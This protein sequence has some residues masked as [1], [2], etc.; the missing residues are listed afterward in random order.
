MATG[1]TKRAP[2][3]AKKKAAKKRGS[4]KKTA[5]KANSGARAGSKAK[6]DDAKPT[7]P[8]VKSETRLLETLT[9]YANNSRTHSDEQI[10]A[11]CRSIEEFGWTMPILVDENDEIIAGH[12]RA[13]AAAKLEIKTVPVMVARGWTDEQRRAYVIADNKLTEM[14]G[15][16]EQILKFELAELDQL[17]FDFT[18]TGF[19]LDFLEEKK[20]RKGKTSLQSADAEALPEL[21][22]V[23]VAQP[24]DIFILGDHRIMCGDSTKKAHVDKLMKGCGKINT[25][26]A[27]PPYGMGKESEGVA[28]DNLYGEKLDAFQMQWW[29]RAL[30]HCEK[31]GSAYIWG[32]APDLWRLWYQGGLSESGELHLRN[33]IVWD[34]SSAIGMKAP[35]EHSYPNA[36]ERCLFMMMGQQFLGNQNKDAYWE[37]YEPLRDWMCKERDKVGWKAKQVNEL[38][39]TNMAGHWFGKSQFAVIPEDHY[40]KLQEAAAGKAFTIPYGKLFVEIFPGLV[41]GGKARRTDLQE[42]LRSLRS[43]FDNTHDVMTDVW[44]FGRVRGEDRF[45]HATPKPVQLIGRGL[46]TSTPE[47]GLVYDPFAGTGTTLIAADV[48]G[49]RCN[50]IE[51]MPHYV[52]VVIRRWQQH[53]DQDAKREDGRKFNDLE[54][55]AKANAENK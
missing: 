45:G 36:T 46:R 52:D 24:G 48:L 42:Q 7:W 40:V 9:H 2:G 28:N 20:Q 30:P 12:G 53:A 18:V 21:A 33:E 37:G 6:K 44:Q 49:L 41:K 35:G 5:K 29:R 19:D 1:S 22:A 23:P 31:N 43:F 54:K 32:N 39:G 14:G 50:T 26:M 25:I 38:T 55:L 13:M 8:A 15:W 34:K 27:D 47:G 10:D 3:A 51:L 17:E 4:K 11:L 16:D